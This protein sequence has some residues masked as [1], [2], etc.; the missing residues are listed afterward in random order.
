MLSHPPVPIAE[1]ADHIECLRANDG[2]RFSQEYESIEPGQ[3]FTWEAANFD[4]NKSKNRYANVIAYDHS[5]VLVHVLD[6]VIGSDY[7]NANFMDGY[8]NHNAYIA[9]QV[10]TLQCKDY[11]YVNIFSSIEQIVLLEAILGT[12]CIR[13]PRALLVPK[14]YEVPCW[15][16]ATLLQGNNRLKVLLLGYFIR[17]LGQIFIYFATFLF[18]DLKST[19]RLRP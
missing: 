12:K 19:K 8:R 6:G 2:S 9:T 13:I 14:V 3:Q 7:I 17:E 1:L 18:R 5:R 10:S 11:L 15:E 16:H 4:F